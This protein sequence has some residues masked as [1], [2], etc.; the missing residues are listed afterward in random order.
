[1]PV[2]RNVT[3]ALP[4]ALLLPFVGALAA[5]VSSGAS[6]ARV[7]TSAVFAALVALFLIGFVALT[8][9]RR[10]RA[11][12]LAACHAFM[13]LPFVA[14]G[15]WQALDTPIVQG[16]GRNCGT[17]LMAFLMLAVPVGGFALFGI[18][19]GAGV[20]LAHRST[21]RALRA[22]AVAATAV[23][24]IAL[25]FAAPLIGR[26][27]P[28]TYLASLPVVGELRADADVQL[29]G[30]SF[31]YRR[32]SVT[33][34]PS[35]PDEGPGQPLP[36]RAEC[37]LSGL[38]RME[39]FY[40]AGDGCPALRVLDDAGHDLAVI[41]S[42]ASGR[43]GAGSIAF[44]PSNGE[45]L[46]VSVQSVADR[47]APPIGWIF[48]A[49]LGGIFGAAF[50]FAASRIRRRAA[51]LAGTEAQHVGNGYVVLP[52]GDRVLVD[53]AAE[54]PLGPVVLDAGTERL[55]TY[56]IMGAPTFVSAR[57]G[58]LAVHGEAMTD[59]A[60]SLDAIAIAVAALGGAPL[61][62]A[63]IIGMM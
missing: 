27:D 58:T 12:A 18:G 53:V 17:G 22:G 43:T 15:A 42:P 25:A 33:D 23:A 4:A 31:T 14:I 51:A 47:I 9:R 11:G 59:L 5:I 21:N 8:R 46:A 2:S 26:P 34:P 13:W 61:V 37:Q 48:G 20:G 55:P 1:M 49:A 40:P 54:L 38:D 35:V 57:A 52:N 44:H 30:R 50:V 32:V 63:R 7:S 3:A 16:Y 6:R 56:R 10:P 19:I 60:A 24:L 36:P 39:T 29:L 62:V 28:D 45:E 41:D